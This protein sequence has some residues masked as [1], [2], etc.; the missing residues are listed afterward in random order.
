M[1]RQGA[2]TLKIIKDKEEWRPIAGYEGLYEVSNLGNVKSYLDNHGLSRER[3]IKSHPNTGGYLA[4]KLYNKK[5]KKTIKI[6]R[7]VAEAFIINPDNKEQVNHLDGDK[8]NN[9]VENLQWRTQSENMKHAHATGLQIK[10][11]DIIS[12]WINSNLNL[13]FTG[14]SMDLVRD[15]P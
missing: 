1:V 4:V 6:H 3:L 13:E 5:I 15:F 2:K 10:T 14:N 12:V 7:L 11:N 8:T 9:R